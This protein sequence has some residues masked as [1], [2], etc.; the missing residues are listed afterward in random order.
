MQTPSIPWDLL[1]LS[2][3]RMSGLGDILIINLM[4]TYVHMCAAG[5]LTVISCR[6]KIESSYTSSNFN[7]RKYIL[8]TSLQSYRLIGWSGTADASEAL[9]VV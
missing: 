3:T 9:Q 1:Q 5:D 6:F 7:Q 8:L 2:V 4:S